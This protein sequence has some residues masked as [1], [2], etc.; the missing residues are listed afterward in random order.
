MKTFLMLF[1][2]FFSSSVVAGDI[3]DFQIEGISIGDSLLDYMTE[4][5]IKK[6]IKDNKYMY[7][8]L[9]DYFGEVYLHKETENYSYMS[10]L[11][12]PD[13]KN[14]IIYQVRGVIK[15]DNKNDCFIKQ[16]EI[17]NTAKELFTELKLIKDESIHP[18]DPSGKSISYRQYFIFENRD[19]IVVSCEI[20]R[21]DLRI[22][23]NWDNGLGVSLNRGVVIDWFDHLL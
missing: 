2:L 18:V 5:Q 3:S 20:F 16:N 7:D 1:V 13:D 21:E 22:K 17:I 8:Y 6:E 19:L 11:V 9:T 10:F 12:K 15:I 23:N 4:D 14:Y